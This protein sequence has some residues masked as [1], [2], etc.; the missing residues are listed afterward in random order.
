[1]TTPQ[2]FIRIEGFSSADVAG[3]E[4]TGKGDIL[5]K[6]GIVAADVVCLLTLCEL[7]TQRTGI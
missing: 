3:V 6:A 4:E 1:M 2:I 7:Y 5:L